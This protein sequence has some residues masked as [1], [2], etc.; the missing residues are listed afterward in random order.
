MGGWVEERRREGG[1][2]GGPGTGK[3]GATRG[4]GLTGGGLTGGGPTGGGGGRVEGPKIRAF[5]P[6]PPFFFFL[7]RG[8]L[9][10]LWSRVAAMDHP[11]LCVWASLRSFCE[12][13][14]ASGHNS[15]R[16]PPPPPPREKKSEHG[17]GEG[18]KTEFRA[19]WERGSRE[20]SP[21]E[22]D[23]APS[24]GTMAWNIGQNKFWL[25]A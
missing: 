17:A 6:L 18:K 5:F 1:P 24:D 9:V 2:V 13:P 15:T 14:T 19:G 10:D 22:W 8:S 21:G 11:K 7:S 20:G 16:R 12:T 25:L 4:G 23:Q 3:V